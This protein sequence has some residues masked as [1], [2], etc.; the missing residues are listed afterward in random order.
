[1]THRNFIWRIQLFDEAFELKVRTTNDAELLRVE[2][3]GKLIEG[4]LVFAR[5]ISLLPFLTILL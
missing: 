4:T 1:M 2:D 5:P 3:D